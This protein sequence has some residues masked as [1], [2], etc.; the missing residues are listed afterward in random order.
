[1]R[2]LQN[3][4][5]I[6]HQ[7]V[8]TRSLNCFET[9]MARLFHLKFLFK[10]Y[11]YFTKV[12]KI[13]GFFSRKHLKRFDIHLSDTNV[14]FD[15][16]ESFLEPHEECRVVTVVDVVLKL[17]AL[18]VKLR[19]LTSKLFL[20]KKKIPTF[21]YEVQHFVDDGPKLEE[22]FN[23]RWI[24]PKNK[25]KNCA[26]SLCQFVEHLFT[27]YLIYSTQLEAP[28]LHLTKLASIL[29]TPSAKKTCWL[30]K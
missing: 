19:N 6:K 20:K 22:F 11:N 3:Y 4:K 13:V 7:N 8:N 14:G 24:K 25:I 21:Y 10:F 30:T 15:L 9:L 18:T 17:F 29:S 12:S 26:Y 28:T 5:L 27:K 16:V 23:T 2:D 1:M